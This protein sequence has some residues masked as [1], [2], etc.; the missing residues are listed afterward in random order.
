MSRSHQLTTKYRPR[1][2]EETGTDEG[3]RRVLRSMLARSALRVLIAGD[4]GAGKSARSRT[5]FD[6]SSA[7]KAQRRADANAPTVEHSSARRRTR[8]HLWQV[9]WPRVGRGRGRG[10]GR[11]GRVI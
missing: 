10:T 2:L 1:C 3:T 8:R 5:G 7:A 11:A 4:S 9:G 6:H